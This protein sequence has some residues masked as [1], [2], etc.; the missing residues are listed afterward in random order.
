M[1]S[2]APNSNMDSRRRLPA[3][4]GLPSEAETMD[5]AQPEEVLLDE[6]AEA[7]GHA[8]WDMGANEARLMTAHDN[9]W[10]MP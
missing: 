9:A 7:V 3:G 5:M 1:P 6:N 4:A 8:F 10:R 2:T